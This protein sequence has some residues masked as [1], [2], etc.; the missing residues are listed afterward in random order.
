MKFEIWGIFDKIIAKFCDE[1]GK[2]KLDKLGKLYQTCDKLG[3][4]IMI[5]FNKICDELLCIKKDHNYF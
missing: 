1:L 2:L 4:N 3:P 5:N